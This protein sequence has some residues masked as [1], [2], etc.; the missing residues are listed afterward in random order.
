M[1]REELQKWANVMILIFGG[2]A[3]FYFLF[4]YVLVLVL[5]FFL[6]FLLATLT[7]PVVR[8]IVAWRG[9]SYRKV[10]ATVTAI[11]LL[12]LALF[13]F[14]FCRWVLLEAQHLLSVLS[15]QGEE[16]GRFSA[17]ASRVR[18]LLS[19]V[20]LSDRLAEILPLEGILEDPEVFLQSELRRLLEAAISG[21]AGVAA[22][23]LRRLPRVLL[24]L[25]VSVI[26]CFFIATDYD[27]V[28]RGVCRMLPRRASARLPAL[29]SRTK[30]ILKRT[31]WGYMLLFL[32][33]FGEL[34]VGLWALRAHYPAVL[35]FFV[36][37]LDLLPVIGVGTVL[38]PWALLSFA[39]GEVVRGIGLVALFLL[40]TVVRQVAEPH[41]LGKSLGLHPLLLL[42][43]FYVGLSLFGVGGVL[44]GPVLALAAST[45][46]RRAKT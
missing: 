21:L 6:A 17:L 29:A 13:L 28:L 19:R 3:L 41:I 27:G 35:A 14:L 34:S 45:L 10:A 38:I 4:R 44:V 39:L 12:L 15:E 43:G 2:G 1:G 33:T 42:G 8:R 18:E 25:L 24:F 23:V 22:E 7:R 37:F 36:A 9:W 30:D 31:V 20:P 40:I 11:V 5:P 46:L 32:L 26:S 16:T